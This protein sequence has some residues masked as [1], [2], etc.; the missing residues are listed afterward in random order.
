MKIGD[1]EIL[2]LYA[3]LDSR[4]RGEFLPLTII[5]HQTG[6]PTAQAKAVALSLENIN[7]IE[8]RVDERLSEDARYK[9]RLTPSGLAFMQEILRS[10]PKK[11]I[12][13]KPRRPE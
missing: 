4:Q 8:C 12:I 13:H 2:L 9:Y 3:L 6:L 7:L 11:G 5:R 10:P 1:N